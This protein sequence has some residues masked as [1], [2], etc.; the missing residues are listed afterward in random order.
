[1]DLYIDKANLISFVKSKDNPLFQD[2]LKLLKRQL[3]IKFNF[4]KGELLEEKQLLPLLP[5]LTEGVGDSLASEWNTSFPERPLKSNT[6][7]N[8]TREQLS[9][10]Y[11]LDDERASVFKETGAV[12]VGMP[13]DEIDIFKSLFLQHDDY[14][15]EKDLRIG[16]DEFATWNDI[17]CFSLPL[18]DIIIIDPYLLKEKRPECDVIEE[19]LLTW[20]DAI[21]SKSKSKINIVIVVAPAEIRYELEDIRERIKERIKKVTGKKSEVTFVKTNKEHDRTIITNYLRY[22]GNSFNYFAKGYKITK[23]KELNIKSLVRYDNH[24][25]ADEAIKDV[26]AIIDFCMKN[27]GVE[28]DL[29]SGYLSFN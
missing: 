21:C 28:G 2:S 23:G 5:A 9:A 7:N 4:D 11:L 15:F 25:K 27:D 29:D 22:S 14:I 1:M 6:H 18:T 10:V 13:G 8:F 19:N 3:N 26:Q 24:V 12:L 17:K 16:S 20:L